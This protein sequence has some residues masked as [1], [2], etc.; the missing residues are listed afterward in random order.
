MYWTR[1][2]K[3]GDLESGLTFAHGTT[4]LNLGKNDLETFVDP[5]DA[6]LI[7]G[8][9]ALE[10]GDPFEK[11]FPVW[12]ATMRRRGGQDAIIESLQR[13]FAQLVDQTSLDRLLE[14][15]AAHAR[16]LG[17]EKVWLVP[18]LLKEPLL[19]PAV[20]VTVDRL[21]KPLVVVPTSGMSALVL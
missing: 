19:G 10:A 8:F 4:R 15:T 9:R 14:D 11:S 17:Y 18:A 16:S 20:K 3:R 5:P 1:S 13:I 2:V 12:M 6:A 21:G 7:F